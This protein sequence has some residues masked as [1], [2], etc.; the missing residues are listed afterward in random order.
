M[1]LQASLKLL[2]MCKKSRVFTS[3]LTYAFV[4]VVSEL[5]RLKLIEHGFTCA[6]DP[7]EL[8]RHSFPTI[9][10]SP[11]ELVSCIGSVV[12]THLP[13]P[14]SAT[15][16]E[17]ESLLKQTNVTKKS[18]V[19]SKHRRLNFFSSELPASNDVLIAFQ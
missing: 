1:F 10:G 16:N 14:E 8:K 6:L 17:G 5:F 7:V 4:N 15:T 13:S 12:A 9:S 3:L 18:N 11:V 19:D 2:K